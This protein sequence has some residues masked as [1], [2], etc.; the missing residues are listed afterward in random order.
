M[1]RFWLIPLLAALLVIGPFLLW[2]ETLEALYDIEGVVA[3]MRDRPGLGWA[4]GAGLILLDL[5][6]P[7]PLTAVVAALGIVYGPVVGGAVGL[8]G[9]TMAAALG[10]ALGRALGRPAAIRFL[11]PSVAQGERL[12]ARYGG[13]IVCGSRWAPVLPEVVSFVAGV[14]RMPFPKFLLAAALGALPL[15]ALFATLGHLGADEPVWT[16]ALCAVAPILLWLIA[17][18]AGLTR[19][20]TLEE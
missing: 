14:G 12:F 10:Y 7:I 8:A 4:L 20:L 6:L 3:M 9:M 11:G 15:C 13:W 16:L 19:R 1:S 17:D 5:F 2:G 18:R